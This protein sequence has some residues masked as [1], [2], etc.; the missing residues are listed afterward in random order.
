MQLGPKSSLLVKA[1]LKDKITF[2]QGNIT[3]A[4][5]NVFYSSS[6]FSAEAEAKFIN[7]THSDTQFYLAGALRLYY[8]PSDKINIF[9]EGSYAKLKYS[10]NS[11]N[12]GSCIEGTTIKG[13]VILTF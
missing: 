12:D 13:G 5:A 6:D 9:A 3:T 1:D 10:S 4:N 2:G 8:T 7:T 11:Q